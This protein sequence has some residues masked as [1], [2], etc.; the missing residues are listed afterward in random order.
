MASPARSRGRRPTRDRTHRSPR[1]VTAQRI[2]GARAHRLPAAEEN[3]LIDRESCS[4][5]DQTTLPRDPPAR[6]TSIPSTVNGERSD[7][8]VSVGKEGLVSAGFSR[9]F[10]R[11][12]AEATAR[13]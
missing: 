11:L 12:S 2:H 5:A 8:C 1:T 10:E 7:D 9:F 6:N 4:A 3:V 13:S